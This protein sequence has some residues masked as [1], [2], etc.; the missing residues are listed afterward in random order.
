MRRIKNMSTNEK[1]QMSVPRKAKGSCFECDFL[2][3]HC[4]DIG[5]DETKTAT[6]GKYPDKAEL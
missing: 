2:S 1:V 4:N 5:M 6:V 3:V